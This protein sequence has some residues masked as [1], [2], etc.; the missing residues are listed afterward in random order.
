MYRSATNNVFIFL[1]A[2][3]QDPKNLAPAVELV[4]QSKIYPLGKK[5]AAEPMKLPQASGVPANMLPASDG[6]EF[7]Q[8]KLLID[9]EGT[10][11]ADSDWLGMLASIG[12]VR[13]QPFIPDERERK[14]LDCAAKT[15][16]KMSRV[17]GMKDLVSGRSFRVYPGRRWVNPVA[18]ATPDNPSRP[19]DLTWRRKDGGYLDLDTRIRYYTDYYSISPGMLS[20]IPGKG[21]K[22][23]VGFVDSDGDLLSGGANYKIHLS[24]STTVCLI[25]IL[26]L[27]LSILNLIGHKFINHFLVM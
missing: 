4:E 23:M 2:F 10:N 19:F 11:L 12:I 1:R 5:D 27:L 26:F 15:G 7:D 25:V 16:Y 6:T 21:A 14:I 13:G 22:Y 24:N 18:N 9:S 20:Q 8:L 3:H 17:I